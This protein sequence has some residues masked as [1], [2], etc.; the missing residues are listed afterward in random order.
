[1]TK[2]HRPKHQDRG[3]GNKSPPARA[4][5]QTGAP[6]RLSARRLRSLRIALAFLSPA[7]FLVLLEAILTL[8]HVGYPTTFFVPAEQQGVLT[9]NGHFGWHYQQQTFTE[10]QPCL[11]AVPKPKDT[12]RVFVLGESAAAG[13]PDPSFGFARILEVMLRPHFPGQRLEIVNAA[14]RGINSHLITQIARECAALHPDLF[15]VYMGNNEFIGLYGPRTPVGFLGPHPRLIRVFHFV[16]RTHT[17]QLFRRVLRVNP[18]ARQ[19]RKPTHTPEFFR[20]HYTSLDDPQRRYVY[21]NFRRHLER[22]CRSG[23]D[24]GAGV[25]VATVA[26]NLRDCPPLGSLHRPDLTA[27]Q[28]AQWDELYRQAVAWESKGDTPRALAACEQAAAIDDH[29]AEL[30]FRLGRC[31][32]RA[33][34]REAAAVEFTQARDWDALQFRADSRINEII[35]E[36]AASLSD[37]GTHPP[38]GR[39]NAPSSGRALRLVEVDKALAASERCP[40]GIP[41]QEFFYEHVHLRFPGDYEVAKTLLPAVVAG[42]RARG[43]TAA[44][45]RPG[46]EGQ[47]GAAPATDEPTAVPTCEECARQLAFTRWDEV[48]TAAAMV[49]MTASLPFRLQLE[50]AQRQAAAE[51]AIAAVT[52]RI[53]EPFVNLATQAYR[54]AI[55]ARPQ[56]WH[57]HYNFGALLLELGRPQEA[58]AH[59]ESVVRLFPHVPAFH[60][61][62]GRAHGSAGRLG[63]AIREFREALR[64]DPFCRPARE[65][66]AWARRMSKGAAGIR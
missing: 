61:Q 38:D 18:E 65:G 45:A 27:A 23:L 16:K 66:L 34:E 3:P 17:G 37:P 62:L 10:P 46:P 6:L 20:A 8:F 58:A 31:R 33:G 19:N 26:V 63:E 60:V 11:L 35:R 57:L 12:I 47:A 30:R 1:M 43:L 28:R 21:R 49:K 64:R 24:A 50:H 4:G 42:L 48:N 36:V 56:D 52:D 32:L 5:P 39:A 51:K 59:F 54:Q 25:V 9:T 13:T 29:Y 44:A 41:G 53:D 40:D 2:S 55:A 7:V 14:M 22:I 15:V